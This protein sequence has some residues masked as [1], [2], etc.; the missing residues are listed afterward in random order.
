MY[1]LHCV[2]NDIVRHFSAMGRFKNN[3]EMAKT[4]LHTHMAVARLTGVS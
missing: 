1:R 2:D 4:S 3:G